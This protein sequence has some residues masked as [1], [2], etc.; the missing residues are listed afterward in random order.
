MTR[1]KSWVL[2]DRDG[3]IWLDSFAVGHDALPLCGGQPWSVRKRTLRGGLSDGVD[4]VEVANGALSFTVLPTRGM[5]LWRGQYRGTFLGWKAPV[6]GP[7]HPKFVDQSERGGLGW[8]RGFDEWLCRCG[9]ASYG[10]PG[11]DAGHF[12]TLHGRIANLPAHHLEVRVGLDPPHELSVIG[13]VEESGLFF[14]H[15]GLTATYTTAP[16]SNR[17][18]IHDVVVNRS[19]EAAELQL[20]YHCNLGA[21]L[22]EA[23]SRVVAP[24]R[25]LAP[26]DARAAQGVESHD[27]FAGPTPGFAEQVFYH[28]LLA[29]AHGRTLA[30][31]HNARADRALV[32][33]FNPR[34][35]PFFVVWKNTLP[36]EDGYVAGLEPATGLPNFKAFERQQGRVKRLPPG[37]R[38]ECTWSLEV[39]DS[40]A[41]VAD[42]LKEIAVLQAQAPARIHRTPRPGWSPA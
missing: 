6:A 30:M 20:L 35:L 3:E 32:L 22:L 19:A 31:L 25:E 5:G 21:P 17:L 27:S 11:D 39:L 34:E 10:P 18:V 14:P 41:A 2:T 7:V 4:V 40:A 29:D 36:V 15:L 23:G 13:Q 26:R 24:L 42:V 9:L 38:W 16:G 37:G 8:L 12:L 1:F 33:R 28:E